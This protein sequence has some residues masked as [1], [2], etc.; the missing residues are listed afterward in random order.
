MRKEIRYMQ[1]ENVGLAVLPGKGVTSQLKE[2]FTHP[3]T[4]SNDCDR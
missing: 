3:S 4:D 1:L 2:E